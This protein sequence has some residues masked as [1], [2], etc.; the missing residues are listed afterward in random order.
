MFKC[1]NDQCKEITKPR[2]PINRII[3]ENRIKHYIN[4]VKKGRKT[5]IIES[6]G[7]EIIK[8]IAVCPK[9]YRTITGKEPRL[10]IQT[11]SI[12]VERE[13]Y[14]KPHPFKKNKKGK[15]RNPR[16]GKEYNKFS[17]KPR[18]QEEKVETKVV[19]VQTVNP[20]PMVK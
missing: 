4:K 14:T 19:V 5:K 7:K 9:C 18:L 10:H 17:T 20:L 8:E 13:E 16:V 6:S 2:Q 12:L 15:W 3:V 11:G 1:E